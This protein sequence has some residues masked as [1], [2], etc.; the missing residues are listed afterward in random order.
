[1]DAKWISN[2]CQTD[3]KR[4]MNE[5][6]INVKVKTD[7]MPELPLMKRQL[8]GVDFGTDVLGRSRKSSEGGLTVT[9]LYY[10]AVCIN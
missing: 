7:V 3:A 6:K 9:L 10:H 4:M 8:F 2:G 5:Y 1:M